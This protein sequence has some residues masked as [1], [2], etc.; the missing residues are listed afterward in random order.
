MPSGI[1]G[2]ISRRQ[3]TNVE[4][5]VLNPSLPFASYGVPGKIV[6]GKFVPLVDSDVAASIY[7]FY[8]RPYPTTG[9]A[10]SDPLGTGTPPAGG[11][12]DGMK[13]GYMT[14]KNNA[15]TPALN[16]QVYVRVANPSS[17]KPINGIEATF[18]SGVVGTA[19]SNTGNGTIGTLSSTS[20]SIPGTYV[21][22]MLTATT[23]R[24]V[25]PLGDRLADGATGSAYSSP[26]APTFTITVGGTAFIAGDSF[27]VA[28]THNTVAI[29]NCVFESAG[30]ASGNVEIS[31][32]M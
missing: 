16:A 29:P 7:A 10:A 22:T 4:G 8:V 3:T 1:P 28:N 11:V 27:T 26:L 20:T 30:D 24:V 23:F 9:G 13:R 12:G 18:E 32:K 25:N 2:D 17:G 14:V 15:G 19:G 6:S 5:L 21:V 31:Y